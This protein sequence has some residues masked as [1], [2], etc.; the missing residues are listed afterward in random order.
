MIEKVF[1]PKYDFM[2]AVGRGALAQ[3]VEQWPEEPRVVG[4]SPTGATNMRV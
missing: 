1:L 4:S 2:V 3:L